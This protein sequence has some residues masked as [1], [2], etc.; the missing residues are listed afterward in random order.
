MDF[1]LTSYVA[2][3]SMNPHSH[4]KSSF[5]VVLR[6]SY[7]E[8]ICGRRTEHSAGSMLFYPAGEVHSQQFGRMPPRKL[9]FAP[10]PTSLELLSE[11]GIR[12]N[13]APHVD[14][15][16]ISEIAQRFVA[17]TRNADIFSG[18]ASTVSRSKTRP[19]RIAHGVK[20]RLSLQ[21]S[22]NPLRRLSLPIM[23]VH[24]RMQNNILF[25]YCAPLRAVPSHNETSISS[26]I[27]HR[28]NRLILVW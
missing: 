6:G 5:T 1:R 21:K 14:M 26:F 25:A 13:S 11:K 22:P 19:L 20:P 17:E 10:P 3:S 23:Y 8:R 7:E 12:L 2:N 18:L 28:S 15:A 24:N 27:A 16:G 9:I 4:E